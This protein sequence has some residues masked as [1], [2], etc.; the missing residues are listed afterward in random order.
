MIP[1]VSFP[2]GWFQIQ[3]AGTGDLLSHSY[4]WNSP[5]L[6]H[7]PSSPIPSEYRESWEFQWTLAHSWCY[8]MNVGAYINSWRIIN[9]LT[10]KP[11]SPR[12]EAQTP[13]NFK[14]YNK[15]LDWELELDPSY[16][17]K[18]KNRFT[19]CLLRQTSVPRGGGTAA[20][21][22]NRMFT[23]EGGNMSWVLR[24]ICSLSFYWHRSIKQN[25]CDRPPIL[26]TDETVSTPSANPVLF[27]R[28]SL[29][30]LVTTS[31]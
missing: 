1:T 29:S 31:V 9:R 8:D 6:L 2:V 10:R 3:N 23:G 11:L 25:C 17:W 27:H 16:N 15:N 30:I 14:G 24:Y 4:L 21:C 20:M 26:R 7:P 5:V 18:L 12:F 22:D 28:S 19:S 13:Q